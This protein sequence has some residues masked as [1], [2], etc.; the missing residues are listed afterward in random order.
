MKK[1]FKI[2]NILVA[3]LVVFAIMQLV[4][5]DTKNPATNPSDV[6]SEAAMTPEVKGLL[7]AACYDCHSNNTKYPWYSNIAPVS[8]WL[9]NHIHEGREELNFSEW[10][11]MD[12]KKKDHKLKECV[13]MIEED[14]MPMN[15]YTWT[16]TDARLNA[17]QKAVLIRFFN[18][19]RDHS[20]DKGGDGEENESHE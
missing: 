5:I 16:H 6:L 11:A 14:E 13:E 3:L 15:S 8:W 1:Y 18:S 4:R 12:S 17:E 20:S 19:L 9:Q 7:S 10:N 2:K